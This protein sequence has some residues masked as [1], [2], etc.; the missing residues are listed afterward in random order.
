MDKVADFINSRS[1]RQALARLSRLALEPNC[2]QDFLPNIKSWEKH[3]DPDQNTFDHA[4][5]CLEKIIDKDPAASLTKAEIERDPILWLQVIDSYLHSR[6]PSAMTGHLQSSCPSIHDGDR[7]VWLLP[8]TSITPGGKFGSQFEN[9]QHWLKYHVFIPKDNSESIPV[10]IHEIPRSYSDW[11]SAALASDPIRI[12]IAHFEDG[13]T[14]NVTDRPPSHFVCDD[15]SDTAKRSSTT[16]KL[17]KKAKKAGVQVLVMPELTIT[18]GIAQEI[19]LEMERNSRQYGQDHE[20]AVPIVILGSFHEDCSGKWRNHSRGV[21]GIDGQQVFAAD[22][23]KSVTYMEKAEWIESAPTPFICLSTPIG[24]MSITICKDLFD[25]G[26]PSTSALLN[27]L[28]LDWLLVPSMSQ[29]TSLHREKAK[30]L[31][32]TLGT[33][34]AVANQ[35]MPQNSPEYGFVHYIKCLDCQSELDVFEVIRAQTDSAPTF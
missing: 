21:L 19:T 5:I 24:L 17:I 10:E 20:L 9:L 11:L 35:E 8:K 12:A 6:S 29:S 7:S 27:N 14:P 18:P 25:N 33:I 4:C 31:Y 22:K 16:L 15:L 13:V 23:R 2:Q 34:V 3:H 26:T 30:S 1:Y 32:N 28:P